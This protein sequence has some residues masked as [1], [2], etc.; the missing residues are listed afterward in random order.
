MS[1][2]RVSTAYIHF[3]SKASLVFIALPLFQSSACSASFSI[4]Q[5]N[6]D[7][8]DIVY[9]HHAVPSNGAIKLNRVDYQFRVG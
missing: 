9:E 8:S 4:T 6:H 3:L 5:F 7:A 2:A 1:I